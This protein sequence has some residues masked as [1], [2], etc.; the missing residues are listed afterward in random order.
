MPPL[1]LKSKKDEKEIIKE[2]CAATDFF[3]HEE[4]KGLQ[5]S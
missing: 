3:Y 2:I 1:T 4:T 5:A